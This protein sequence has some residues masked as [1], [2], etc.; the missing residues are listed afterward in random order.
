MSQKHVVPQRPVKAI[1]AVLKAF[2]Y[3]SVKLFTL[4][5]IY[6]RSIDKVVSS[7]QSSTP[8]LEST[9]KMI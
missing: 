5:N 9:L 7:A 4:Y 2:L 1:E 3:V 6:Y 8:E